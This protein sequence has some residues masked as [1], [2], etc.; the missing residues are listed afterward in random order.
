MSGFLNSILILGSRFGSGGGGPGGVTTIITSYRWP[1]RV[2]V[3]EN[4]RQPSSLVVI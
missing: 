1:R 3:D 4:E 2:T